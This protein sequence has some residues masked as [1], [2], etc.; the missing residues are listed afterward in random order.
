MNSTMPKFI[1]ITELR[2]K[3]REV[4]DAVKKED[5]PVVI[6]RDSK[7]EAVIIP[8]KEYDKLAQEQ[9]KLWNSRL[10]KLTKAAK[11]YIASWLKKKGYNPKKVTGD[12]LVT[13]LDEDDKGSS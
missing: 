12:K 1:G 7:P 9:R 13:I 6:M 8:F 11:P 10:D 3:T 2:K 4:F 5:L